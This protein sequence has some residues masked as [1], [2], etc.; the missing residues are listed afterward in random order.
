MQFHRSATQSHRD[1]LW[2]TVLLAVADEEF[3]ARAKQSKLAV[4]VKV[5]DI[6]DILFPGVSRE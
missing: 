2:S 1:A 4:Q 5:A 6:E 3:V